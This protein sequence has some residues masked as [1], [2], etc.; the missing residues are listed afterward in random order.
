MCCYFFVSSISFTLPTVAPLV[1][2]TSQPNAQT[3]PASMSRPKPPPPA[4]GPPSSVGQ[5]AARLVQRLYPL[6]P[7]SRV[8]KGVREYWKPPP[9]AMVSSR[10]TYCPPPPSAHRP[11]RHRQQWLRQRWPGAP[12]PRLWGAG[13]G[14]GGTR[15]R[16]FPP[17]V[18]FSTPRV[19]TH[20]PWLA[21]SAVSQAAPPPWRT[22][23][24]NPWLHSPSSEASMSVDP[25]L[26][27]N[28]WWEPKGLP[29]FARN[30]FPPI[31][32]P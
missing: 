3:R 23:P 22:P 17:D 4:H 7:F 10:R 6:P 24:P 31:F 28:E 25:D 15:D 1:D 2:M 32:S 26:N 16:A 19:S 20:S 14:R 9:P 8:L 29:S 18:F 13:P 5:K 30:G 11:H 27:L 21:P 12:T